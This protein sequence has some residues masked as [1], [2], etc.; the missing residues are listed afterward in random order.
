MQLSRKKIEQIERLS[1]YVNSA[2]YAGKQIAIRKRLMEVRMKTNCNLGIHKVFLVM[3]V[4]SLISLNAFAQNPEPSAEIGLSLIKEMVEN[5]QAAIAEDGKSWF[6]IE[7]GKIYQSDL[8]GENRTHIEGSGFVTNILVFK[9][10]LFARHFSGNLFIWKQEESK[11]YVF[12]L[13]VKKF[14]ASPSALITQTLYGT[15]W[16]FAPEENYINP[17]EGMY[18][19]SGRKLYAKRINGLIYYLKDTGMSGVEDI[20]MQGDSL[21]VDFKDGGKKIYDDPQDLLRGAMHTLSYERDLKPKLTCH[22]YDG[23]QYN[24]K[25]LT[26]EKQLGDLHATISY[27]VEDK[28]FDKSPHYDIPF[29]E[30]YI[31]SGLLYSGNLLTGESLEAIFNQSL[32]PVTKGNWR[33]SYCKAVEQKEDLPRRNFYD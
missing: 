9:G 26:V 17:T 13:L 23:R 19:V 24:I 11:W 18:I 20:E 2:R 10:R 30:I 33:I 22:F 31:Y 27:Q 28:L 4:S 14:V 32:Q 25:S 3:V 29:E 12:A 8:S 7:D 16:I 6:Y 21:W 1:S 5:Q 15:V